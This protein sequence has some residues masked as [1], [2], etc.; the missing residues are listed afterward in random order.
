MNWV[1][2]NIILLLENNDIFFC[3]VIFSQ[4]KEENKVAKDSLKSLR[5]CVKKL[6]KSISEGESCKT[7]CV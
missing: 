6:K 7:T 2:E 4:R 3:T 5:R 1:Q